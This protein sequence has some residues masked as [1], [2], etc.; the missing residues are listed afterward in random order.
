L[1][2]GLVRLGPGDAL[3]D[4][5]SHVADLSLDR[6]AYEQHPPRP[7]ARVTGVTLHSDL[8]AVHDSRRPL[9]VYPVEPAG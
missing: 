5:V 4:T 8:Q 1:G 7:S 6:I 2:V 3:L 9:G